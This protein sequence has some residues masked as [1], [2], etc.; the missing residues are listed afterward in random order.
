MTIKIDWEEV[1]L[2]TGEN[3]LFPCRREFFP[4]F[5]EPEEHL[6]DASELQQGV[7]W[8]GLLPWPFVGAY[9]ERQQTGHAE[10]RQSD[11]IN[12]VN[13]DLNSSRVPTD[14]IARYRVVRKKHEVEHKPF[15]TAS[16]FIDQTFHGLLSLSP[17]LQHVVAEAR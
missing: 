7:L 5:Y 15:A 4:P 16:K 14:L 9:S 1:P 17:P 10:Q 12:S 13:R 6:H 2:A 3:A 8:H 11:L